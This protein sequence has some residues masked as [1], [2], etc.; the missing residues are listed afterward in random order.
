MIFVNCKILQTTPKPEHKKI[1]EFEFVGFPI[2]GSENFLLKSNSSKRVERIF[3]DEE[4]P[5]EIDVRFDVG[6]EMFDEDKLKI[7]DIDPDYEEVDICKFNKR[8]M[9]FQSKYL[10]S[11][12]K[13]LLPL[14]YDLYT[15][16]SCYLFQNSGIEKMSGEI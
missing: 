16:S 9:C 11:V 5:E 8:I 14:L 3:C 15:Q 4:K 12:I 2:K 13:F 10:V 6:T 1:C 7:D